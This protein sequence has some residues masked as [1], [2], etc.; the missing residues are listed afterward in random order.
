MEKRRAYGLTTSISMIVGIVIG[1]GIFFKADD[2]L[3]STSGNV[4]L[5]MLALTLGAMAIIFGSLT[6]SEFATRSD[7][8]G[9][10]VDYFGNFVSNKTAGGFGT[11][12]TLIY[13]PTVNVIV[14]YASS[15]YLT[16]ILGIKVS[17]EIQILIAY[18]IF[19]F[20]LIMNVLSRRIG[21]Y[22][23]NVTAI[24]KLIPLILVAILGLSSKSVSYEV[25]NNISFNSNI[26]WIAALAPITFSY[27]GWPISTT[28]AGE[29][30]AP[31]R[32][33]PIALI[34]APIIILF[35]YLL[36][37]YGVTNILEPKAI[38]ELSDGYL[39]YIFVSLFGNSAGKILT[40]LVF[41]AIVGVVNGLSLGGIRMP[42]ALSE[43]NILFSKSVQ[44]INP[45]YQISIKSSIIYFII[46]SIWMLLHY[47]ITKYGLLNNSDI[48]EIAVA[49]SYITYIILY[50][51]VIS[52]HRKGEIKGIFRGIIAPLLAIA[53]ALF[54][55]FGALSINF[56]NVIIYIVFCAIV[57]II[58][59]G[60]TGRK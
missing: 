43:R 1:S 26:S 15:I 38:M 51:K 42:Q 30:K 40:I 17:F 34:V 32:N 45:K 27:D 35:T 36:F 21:G 3:K 4:G 53:T 56:V 24:I 12:Q 22:F 41:I 52:M 50:V 48:S 7:R 20:I 49:F 46:C 60:F 39:N 5:G 16:I 58:G 33:M 29:V 59:Y 57:F 37:F 10:L 9:G 18:L 28:I 54:V 44:K 31:K 8:N 25:T 11:F 23:Q 2:I 13:Y 19:I 55:T 14:S 6:I 47:V